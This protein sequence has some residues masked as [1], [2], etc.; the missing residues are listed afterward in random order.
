MNPSCKKTKASQFDQVSA[1]K[2]DP[3]NPASR[4][5]PNAKQKESHLHS[6]S[7]SKFNPS[8]S[9]IDHCDQSHKNAKASLKREIKQSNFLKKQD[10]DNIQVSNESADD[11]ESDA[12]IEV[13]PPTGTSC[14]RKRRP[15]LLHYESVSSEKRYELV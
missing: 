9:N 12:D 8:R 3:R 2:K 1:T 7:V 10:T 14:L 5:D 4:S 15:L 13:Q 11:F 6:K